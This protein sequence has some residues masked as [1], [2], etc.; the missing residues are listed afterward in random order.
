MVSRPAAVPR[1]REV[2]ADSPV[3]PRA[4]VSPAAAPTPVAKPGAAPAPAPQEAKADDSSLDFS[5]FEFSE[6]NTGFHVEEEVDPVDAEAE[7]AAVLFANGQDL[8]ACAVLEQATQVHHNAAGERLW[9]MLFDFYKLNG[10]AAEFEKLENEFVRV[11]EKSPPVWRNR[12]KAP[13]KAKE[14]V[15]GSLLFKGDLVGENQAAFEPIRQALEK[16]SKLRLD[17][18]KVTR[19]DTEGCHL[20][21]ALLQQARKTKKEIELLGRDALGALVEERVEPGRAEDSECWLLLLEL[22]QL[23]GQQE[24]F[25]EVAINY[26]VTFEVSPP[27]WEPNRV[28]APEPATQTSIEVPNDPTAESY[29][30]YGDIKGLRFG[31]L[32]A[33]AELHDPVI[34]DCSDLIRI[35][36]VSAGVLLN[37]L[38]SVRGGGKQ[39]IFRHPNHLVAEL[40]RIV[41]LK[42]LATIVFAKS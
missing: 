35:D 24:A 10:Q 2:S 21:M 5:G 8:A 26:A 1:A 6:F 22:C 16:N 12:S 27:S 39:I 9:M 7:E 31:D 3:S 19:I 13:A 38:T 33:Y 14:A 41:G 29:R 20:L 23:Q 17:M 11:F 32:P 18:S 4:E 28:A 42:A 30:L 37:V 34:V 36:F 40:F 25:D 15:A